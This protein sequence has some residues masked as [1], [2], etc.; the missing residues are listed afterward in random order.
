MAN[1][2]FS[3]ALFIIAGVLLNACTGSDSPAEKAGSN[4]TA[5]SE[6]TVRT[7]GT[8]VDSLNGIPGH[9]FGEPLSAFP[10]IVLAEGVQKPGTQTY[11]YPDGK[12]AAGWFGKHK[13]KSPDQ[14]FVYYVFQDGKFVAFQA[15]AF[16]EGRQALQE[17]ALYLFGPGKQFPDGTTWAG[18]KALAY[19][20]LPTLAKGP[21]NALDVKS[22][23]FVRSQATATAARLKQENAGQ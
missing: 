20:T 2:S 6:V 10:G 15:L 1:C 3:S 7:K 8:R 4:E 22:Q 17:Q 14:F 18:E 5:P 11:T 19:Y 16:G 21:A 23:E 13:A 12:P 9:R